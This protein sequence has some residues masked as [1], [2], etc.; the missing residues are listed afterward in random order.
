MDFGSIRV[1]NPDLKSLRKTE[2][3]KKRNDGGK[4]GERL[5]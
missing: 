3:C 5:A 1:W 2:V 4:G